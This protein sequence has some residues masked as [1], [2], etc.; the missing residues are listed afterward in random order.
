VHKG[1]Q[2]QK[3]K[4]ASRVCTLATRATHASFFAQSREEKNRKEDVRKY[5]SFTCGRRR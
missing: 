1:D 3:K 4:G 2:D 5:E